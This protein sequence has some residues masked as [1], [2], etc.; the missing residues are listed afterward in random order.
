MKTL[1]IY[2]SEAQTV[3]KEDYIGYIG[4]DDT[5]GNKVVT[6]TERL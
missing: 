4:F 5:K 2:I 6:P 1:F 3:I